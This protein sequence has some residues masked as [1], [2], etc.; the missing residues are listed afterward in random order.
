MT[1]MHVEAILP[2]HVAEDLL[3]A[4]RVYGLRREESVP[5]AVAAGL[6]ELSPGYVERLLDALRGGAA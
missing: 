4:E 3:E 2:Q 1:T 6:R 5:I